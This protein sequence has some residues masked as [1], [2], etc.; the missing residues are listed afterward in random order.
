ML[1]RL[2]LRALDHVEPE[3]RR[4]WAVRLAVW[5]I[6]GWAASHVGLLF[7]PPWFFEHV[8][9]AISWGA[10]LITALDVVSTTDVRANEDT[11]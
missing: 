7:A 4:S 10:I 6:I 1:T 11:P 5:T 8:L 9:L 2:L 3:R